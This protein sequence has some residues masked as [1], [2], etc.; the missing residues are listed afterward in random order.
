MNHLGTMLQGQRWVIGGDFNMIK[1]LLEKKGGSRKL[2]AESEAF[3][4]WIKKYRLIDIQTSN[5]PFTWSN[6]RREENRISIRLDRFLTS[7][8]FVLGP[9]GH[10]NGGTPLLWLK[11][12]AN[13]SVMG[14]QRLYPSQNLFV[15]KFFWMDHMEFMQN[16]ESWWFELPN[17]YGTKMFQFQQRET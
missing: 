3:R 7:E 2:D 4:D 17:L 14:K 8:F 5:G 15:L 9:T 12:L 13:Q 6:K 1:S 11:P 16:I 10:I